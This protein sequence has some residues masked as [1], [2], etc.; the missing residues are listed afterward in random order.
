M[1]EKDLQHLVSCAESYSAL[2]TD[3]VM[4]WCGGCG[5]YAIQNA[6]KRALVLEKLGVQDVLLCFDVGCS[7]NGADKIE[8]FT[9]HGLH[10]RVLPLAAGAK[11]ANSRLTVIALGGDGATLSEGVNHLVHAVRSDY[12]IIFLHHDNQNYALTTGQAS[13]T[14]PKGCRMNG[15]P[16]G[17]VTETIN[18]LSLV[19][20]LQPSFVAQ[21]VSVDTDHM[22]QIFREALHHQGFAF[23]QILQSCP[24]YNRATPDE[25][26]QE[27]ILDVAK[28]SHDVHDLTAARAL[29]ENPQKLP[30]GVLYRH[31]SRSHFLQTVL[32][33][34]HRKTTLVEEVEQ[35]DIGKFLEEISEGQG[36][37]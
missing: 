9:I 37:R 11:I 26:Y 24:T 2:E 17:V 12:P 6:L 5:N 7:G 23:V 33:R 25:W 3:Q 14:T 1:F 30:I 35:G 21:N 20:S 29:V 15:T 31:K 18:G 27:H 19:L 16:D 22:T 36:T 34:D 28:I 13:A 4:T 32:H 10:G 8:L